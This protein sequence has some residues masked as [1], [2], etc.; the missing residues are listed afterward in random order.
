LKKEKEKKGSTMWVNL[1]I[2]QADSLSRL[3]LK[4]TRAGVN[5]PWPSQ[6]GKKA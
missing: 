4:L 3:V 1:E 2:S 5:P 6:F